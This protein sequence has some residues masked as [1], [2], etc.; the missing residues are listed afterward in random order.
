M[1]SPLLEKRYVNLYYLASKFAFAFFILSVELFKNAYLLSEP[2]VI[3]LTGSYLFL[4]FLL[5]RK[6]GNIFERKDVRYI[7]YLLFLVL[8]PLSVN[9]FGIAPLGLV[10]ILYGVIYWSETFILTLAGILILLPMAYFRN[11]PTDDLLVALFYL[12]TVE[13]VSV[14]WNLVSLVKLNLHSL[15]RLKVQL[16]QLNKELA[17][18]ELKLKNYSEV[19]DIAEKISHLD[20][21]ENLPKVLANLLN[22]S[23]VNIYPARGRKKLLGDGTLIVKVGR[24]ILEVEPKYK[25]LLQDRVYKEKLQLLAKIIKPYLES[26]LA[27]SK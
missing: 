15:Q 26:F 23:A 4:N 22:A 6:K 18:R 2:F 14:K 25:F 7:D 21:P 20:K 5:S 11:F 24:L 10:L 17:Y 13:T 16:Q 19:L 8:L 1:A 27:K 3:F 9:F 12:L